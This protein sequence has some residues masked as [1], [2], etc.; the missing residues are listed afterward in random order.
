MSRLTATQII[1]LGE[2]LE[3][4]FDPST[5]T[6]SQLLGILGYHNIQYPTPYSKAKLVQVFN[7]EVKTRS[8][9]LKKDRLKR[10]NSSPSDD[11]IVDGHTGKLI[12]PAKQVRLQRLLAFKQFLTQTF[13]KPTAR[14][15]TRR[16]SQ[17]P[18]VVVDDDDDEPTPPP[19]DPVR[20][21]VTGSMAQQADEQH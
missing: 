2:Y 1:N 13:Y 18:V 14:R 5:L 20:L 17:A 15:T 8:T 16:S 19:P 12:A 10:Q 6:I 4:T 3:P 9:R 11:G 7:D 21:L